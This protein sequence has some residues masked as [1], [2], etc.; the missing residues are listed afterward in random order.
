MGCSTPGARCYDTWEGV[1]T[2]GQ[3]DISDRIAED[4]YD[5]L[6]KPSYLPLLVRRSGAAGG[7]GR[8]PTAAA[9]TG[10]PVAA[11]S[12]EP[13]PWPSR[14]RSPVTPRLAP[15]LTPSSKPSIKPTAKPTASPTGNGPV[16]SAV[17]SNSPRSSSV[18][19][20]GRRRQSHHLGHVC[21]LLQRLHVFPE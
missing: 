21:K 1:C 2:A 8:Y 5:A 15:S 12:S 3:Y 20:S 17:P 14:S 9:W 19:C 13:S 4:V 11:P 7:L 6:V 10:P 18:Q 16:R